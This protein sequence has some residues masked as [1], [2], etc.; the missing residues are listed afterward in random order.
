MRLLTETA[1][2]IAFC[3]IAEGCSYDTPAT[4]SSEYAWSEEMRITSP[5][6][7]LDAVLNTHRGGPVTVGTKWYTFIVPKGKKASS[8]GR[9]VLLAESMTG[10]KLFWRQPHLL[11]IHYDT[12]EILEFRNCWASDDSEH[13]GSIGHPHYYVEIRLEPTSPDFSLLTPSGDFR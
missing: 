2:V 1:T 5:T 12:A 7:Q 4:P 6:G 10:G 13:I 8:V 9:D 11:E 3:L